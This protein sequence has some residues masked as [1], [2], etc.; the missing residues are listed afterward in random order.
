LAERFLGDPYLWPQIWERNQYIL[1]AHWI[2]PGD[3]LLL[4]SVA[5][6]PETL[7]FEGEGDGTGLPAEALE[8]AGA[9]MNVDTSSSAPEPLGSESDIYCSGFI[10]D[11]EEEFPL[12]I[13]GSEY[14]VLAPSLEGMSLEGSEG[15]YGSLESVKFMLSTGDIVYL[16]GGRDRGVMVG[17]VYTVIWPAESVTHPVTKKSVGRI[18]RYQGKVRV[19][20]VQEDRAIAEVSAACGPV[21][22]GWALRPF[23][24]EP[25]PLGRL[26]GLRPAN[27]PVA[28]E[29][30][31][32]APVILGSVNGTLNLGEDTVVFI[33]RGEEH[34]VVPGDMYTVYR[35]NQKGLPPVVMGELAVLSVHR[36]TSLARVV[37]SRYSIYAGDRLDLK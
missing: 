21:V 23:E 29:A 19:M 11:L 32:D 6:Q 24:P 3:P 1:D 26:G 22:V 36:R 37:A 17:D 9:G 34:D 28:A 5:G 2:Y 16:D 18:Y 25:V 7:E 10:G 33:D 15:A 12:H 30:L 14:E 4:S 31:A 35:M 8:G 20:S 27:V 13:A